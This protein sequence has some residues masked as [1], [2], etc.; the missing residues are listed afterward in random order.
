MRN[1]EQMFII[2]LTSNIHSDI[3]TLQTKEQMF[4]RR[5]KRGL[6]NEKYK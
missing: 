1:Y 4:D 5:G 6:S 3:L 2:L